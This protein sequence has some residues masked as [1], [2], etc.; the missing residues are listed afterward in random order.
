[1]SS[2]Y[3]LNLARE[4]NKF[5]DDPSADSRTHIV[6]LEINIIEKCDLSNWTLTLSEVLIE[7]QKQEIELQLHNVLTSYLPTSKADSV[8]LGQIGCAA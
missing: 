3:L 8:H 1:M 5:D 6:G 4:T 2:I 7:R